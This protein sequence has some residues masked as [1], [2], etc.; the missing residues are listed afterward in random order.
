VVATTSYLKIL[1]I[2]YFIE[3]TNLPI[4]SDIVER[5]IKT[6]YIFDD[7]ILALAIVWVDIW[8]FQN[9]MKAKLLINRHFNVVQH[10]ATIRD[11]NMNP[12][13]L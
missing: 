4:T 10:I 7:I 2:P 11:T 9:S 8:N 12:G 6:S 5:V 3:D 1:D 13:F